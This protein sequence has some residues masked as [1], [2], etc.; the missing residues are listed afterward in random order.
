MSLF[1]VIMYSRLLPDQSSLDLFW[2]RKYVF[3][4]GQLPFNKK[5][6]LSQGDIIQLIVSNN[7]YIT[8]R[9]LSI[10]TKQ[11][12]MKFKKLVYRKGLSRKYKLIKQRKQKSYYTP[13]WIYKNRFDFFDVKTF[14]EVDY[15]TLSAVVLYTPYLLSYYTYDNQLD[16]KI[17]TFR[18]YN[19]KYIT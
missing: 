9:W 19:W 15:F 13:S 16:L 1:R 14:L 18:L 11:R 3:V 2:G 6:I 4:N 17:N 5:M 7:Y 10:F 8:Y 12:H